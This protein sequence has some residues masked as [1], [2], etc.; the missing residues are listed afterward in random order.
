MKMLRKLK[1]TMIVLVALM[2]MLIAAPLVVEAATT[3]SMTITATQVNHAAVAYVYV[4]SNDYSDLELVEMESGDSFRNTQFSYRRDSRWDSGTSYNGYV[5]FFVKPLDGYLLTNLTLNT[6]NAAMFPIDDIVS[7]SNHS[8]YHRINEIVALA[9]ENG[10]VAGF[11]YSRMIG[12]SGNYSAEFSISGTDPELLISAECDKDEAHVNDN[13]VFTVTVE[14]IVDINDVDIAAKDVKIM[15][16]GTEADSDKVSWENNGDGTYTI[17]VEHTVTTADEFRGAVELQAEV[18]AEFS[19]DLNL[20]Y[21]N[22]EAHTTTEVT[23]SAS[24][25]VPIATALN[26]SY[27][28]TGAPSDA[29]LPDGATVYAGDTYAVDDEYYPGLRV[30]VTE[31]GVQGDRIFSGWMLNDKVVSGNIIINQHTE[32]VGR[33]DFSGRTYTVTYTDGDQSGSVFDDYVSYPAV[34]ANNSAMLPSPPSVRLFDGYK[35]AGWKLVD[36]QGA[37]YDK[38]GNELVEGEV[39][40]SSQLE[41]ATIYGNMEFAAVYTMLHRGIVYVVLD[42][43][44]DS[45]THTASG[46]LVSIEQV[47]GSGAALFVS[48]VGSDDMIELVEGDDDGMYYAELEPGDYNIYY[49]DGDD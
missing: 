19:Y 2:A 6:E 22:L 12:S 5:M 15:L 47:M 31:N 40:R 38:N 25:I 4:T 35:L 1:E 18:T 26:V 24:T 9:K 32:L 43:T 36:A 14:P 16:N 41:D 34:A 28:W 49:F 21:T 30:R 37:A 39:Y 3:S 27:M 11:G 45:A 8:G 46:D 33:W 7:S 13:V 44:Y 10:Y 20:G 42:G 48:P 17:T 23:S 29:V